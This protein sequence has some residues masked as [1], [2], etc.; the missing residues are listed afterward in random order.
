MYILIMNMLDQLCSKKFN[1]DHW[2]VVE[3]V[4]FGVRNMSCTNMYQ[5]DDD[6]FDC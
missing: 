4:D 2:I 3:S 1:R 5:N 6:I